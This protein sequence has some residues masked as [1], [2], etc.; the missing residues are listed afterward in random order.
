MGVSTKNLTARI[1]RDNERAAI[2]YQ[3][4]SNSTDRK[5]ADGLDALVQA[6]RKQDGDDEDGVAGVP[7]PLGLIARQAAEH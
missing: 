6:E 2:R 5:I 7:V 3:H 1:G 4:K